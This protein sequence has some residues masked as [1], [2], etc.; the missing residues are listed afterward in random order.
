[1]TV[2][3]AI[4]RSQQKNVKVVIESDDIKRDLAIAR[5]QIQYSESLVTCRVGNTYKLIASKYRLPRYKKIIQVAAFERTIWQ[6]D[7]VDISNEK[8]KR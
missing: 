7:I 5:A 2:L 1:M 8:D 3:E 4:A 6:L